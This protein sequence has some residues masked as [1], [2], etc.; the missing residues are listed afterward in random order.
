MLEIIFSKEVLAVFSVV[1][2][3]IAVMS[4]AAVLTERKGRRKR[5]TIRQK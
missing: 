1:I 5:R 3:A 2:A 4:A